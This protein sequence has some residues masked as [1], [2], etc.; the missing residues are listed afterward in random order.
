M[1]LLTA[2]QKENLFS[3]MLDAENRILITFIENLGTRYMANKRILTKND[4]IYP[5]NY[6][7][8]ISHARYD[9]LWD[10]TEN[11]GTLLL[12]IQSRLQEIKLLADKVDA[13]NQE[14]ES[15]RF[16]FRDALNRNKVKF[17]LSGLARRAVN[18]FIRENPS[19]KEGLSE[20]YQTILKERPQFSEK[21]G[22]SSRKTKKKG[23]VGGLRPPMTPIKGEKQK[24]TH[25][26]K[27]REKSKNEHTVKN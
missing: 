2:T 27:S 8:P 24:R 16:A 18:E 22:G 10:V 26:K 1:S 19:A 9:K 15:R 13:Q 11:D 25:G 6:Y 12:Q 4:Y 20:F 17:G 3:E 21:F 7:A 5:I 23:I 14:L